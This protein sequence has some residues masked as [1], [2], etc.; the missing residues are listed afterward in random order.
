MTAVNDALAQ[1]RGDPVEHLEFIHVFGNIVFPYQLICPLDQWP[2]MG[3]NTDIYFIPEHEFQVFE[4]VLIDLL[5]LLVCYFCRLN[6]D[7]LAETVVCW[8]TGSVHVKHLLQVAVCPLQ[9]CLHH[10]SYVPRELSMKTPVK[11]NLQVSTGRV[12]H[13]YPAEVVV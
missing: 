11:F 4:I 3:G 9:V 1:L 10:Q 12:F 2:V 7:A 6:V 5:V 13:V 8:Y